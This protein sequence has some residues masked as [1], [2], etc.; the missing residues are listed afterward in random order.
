MP[1]ATLVRF[2]TPENAAEWVEKASKLT[3]LELQAMLKGQTAEGE[4]TTTGTSDTQTFK[5][6]LHT[7][8][9]ETVQSALSKGKAEFSTEF[10]AVLGKGT[11]DGHSP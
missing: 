2:L 7:D 3:V 1:L 4:K 9:M 10:D 5:V 8:Q 6:K 11:T